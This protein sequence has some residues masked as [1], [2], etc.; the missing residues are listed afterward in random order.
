MWLI[1]A[2]ATVPAPSGPM[3]VRATAAVARVSRTRL[4]MDRC[5]SAVTSNTSNA[6]AHFQVAVLRC[7][8]LK[9]L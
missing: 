4:V 6:A 2:A 3:F 8:S 7:G 1:L 5:S 9:I